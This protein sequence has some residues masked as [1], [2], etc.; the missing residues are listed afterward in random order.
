MEPREELR[1][2][3]CGSLLVVVRDTVGPV[4]LVHDEGG[5]LQRAGTD[6][7][8]ETLWVVCFASS[9]QHAVSDGLP[10]GVTLLQGVLGSSESQVSRELAPRASSQG[11]STPNPARSLYCDSR[12][13]SPH[14]MA[15]PPG[16]RTAVPGAAVHT[17][18]K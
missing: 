13:S 2:D 1:K 6:H 15:P 8:G 7:A 5:T 12:Y 18:G 3:I 14:S 11:S 4:G 16:C 17:G 10:T 9:S